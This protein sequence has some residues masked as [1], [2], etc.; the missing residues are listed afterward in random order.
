MHAELPQVR[1]EPS[2]GRPHEHGSTGLAMKAACA[3]SSSPTVTTRRIPPPG[4]AS[5]S[6]DDSL[7]GSLAGLSALLH[8]DV[9]LCNLH[10][11]RP[12]P[13]ARTHALMRSARSHRAYVA[14]RRAGEGIIPASGLSPPAS[15]CPGA[16]APPWL[17]LPGPPAQTRPPPVGTGRRPRG[18]SRTR[19]PRSRPR[20]AAGSPPRRHCRPPGDQGDQQPGC[21][22]GQPGSRP[23]PARGHPAAARGSGRPGR[24]SYRNPGPLGL[25]TAHSLD[26]V[27][28][29]HP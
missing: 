14:A 6:R 9:A 4:R 2:R 26:P 22:A 28:K 13:L 15:G 29:P 10:L 7:P 16:P 3:S 18:R 24:I 12:R 21:R 5:H 8:A 11:Q 27:V 23:A 20:A 17:C 25:P 19:R 1:P